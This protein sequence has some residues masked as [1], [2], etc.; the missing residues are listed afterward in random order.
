MSSID[1]DTTLSDSAFQILAAATGR[2]WLMIVDSFKTVLNSVLHYMHNASSHWDKA[3]A[4][5]HIDSQT[6]FWSS[7][8]WTY[9]PAK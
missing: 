8:F 4:G 2:A 9:L 1:V 7:D 5:Y 6:S 3:S